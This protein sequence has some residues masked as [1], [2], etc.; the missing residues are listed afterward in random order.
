MEED[1]QDQIDSLIDALVADLHTRL[2]KPVRLG[3]LA[4]LRA[5]AP[6]AT[7]AAVRAVTDNLRK[8]IAAITRE[9]EA[10]RKAIDEAVE[11]DADRRIERVKLSDARPEVKPREGALIVAGRITDKQSG[12]GLPNVTLSIFDL[13]RKHDDP[14]GRTRTD[15]QGYFCFDYAEPQV[16]D[17]KDRK[18]EIY[19]QILDDSGKVIHE[20]PRSF[21]EKA[22]PVYEL[23]AAIDGSK[24]PASRVL[25]EAVALRRDREIARLVARGKGW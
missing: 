1:R 7:A 5:A 12:M 3:S 13:D 25:A 15:D 17:H 24:L 22:G 20:T 10:R 14:L 16:D 8:S 6:E 2:E 21:F 19:L 4:D 11:K 18:A 9:Q 23:D